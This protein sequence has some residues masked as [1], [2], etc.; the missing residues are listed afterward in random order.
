VEVDETKLSY[1][2][3]RF[4][5][6]IQR[7]FADAAGKSDI[8][9]FKLAFASGSETTDA[10]LFACERI[11]APQ[12]DR[13]ALQAHANGVTGI[14]EVVAVSDIAAEQGRLISIATG[15][16]G[17]NTFNLP[18]AALTVLTSAELETRF[19]VPAGAPSTLRFATIVFSVR[20]AVIAAKLLAANGI[21]HDIRGSDIVVQ[22]APGQGAAFIFREPR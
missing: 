11:N 13:T 20:H 22:P 3:V 21:E 18:N 8:A 9:S 16:E 2:Q 4:S 19:G 5:G 10:F 17:E 15:A 14:V 6:Y 1:V 7:V 12:I